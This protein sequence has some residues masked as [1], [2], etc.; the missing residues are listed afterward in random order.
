LTEFA[1]YLGT[2]D[3]IKRIEVTVM[4]RDQQ[5]ESLMI[6]LRGDLDYEGV[7]AHMAVKGAAIHSV[8]AVVVESAT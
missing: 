3:G 8:D 2:L 5:T 1:T 7:R 4:E 6:C